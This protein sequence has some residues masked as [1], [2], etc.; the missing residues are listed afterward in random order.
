MRKKIVIERNGEKFP[1]IYNSPGHVREVEKYG[2]FFEY[3]MLEAIAKLPYR[4]G[5]CLDIGANVGNHTV[6]FS[7]CCNFDEVWAYEPNPESFE[8]LG[9]NIKENCTRTVRAFRCAVGNKDGH[10]V[11]YMDSGKPSESRVYD[12]KGGN[13]RM[14]R[15]TTPLKVALMKIDVEGHEIEVIR[16]AY[17]VIERERPELFIE[18]FDGPGHILKELPEGYRYVRTFNNAPSHQ[19]TCKS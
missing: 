5:I 2:K 13:T 16:G 19:F 8:I 15:I 10:C 14:L 4:K 9:R 12:L 18:H 6:F 11:L 7:R 1:I 3:G 17:E